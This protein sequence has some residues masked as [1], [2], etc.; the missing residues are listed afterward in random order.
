MLDDNL[1]VVR[2]L[3]LHGA[4]IDK[5][6]SDSW[7]PLHAAAANGHYNIVRWEEGGEEGIGWEGG[8]RNVRRK[9]EE[10]CS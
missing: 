10:G 2:L 5:E 1:V 4:A 6:D 8:E 7:T 3:L 9:W